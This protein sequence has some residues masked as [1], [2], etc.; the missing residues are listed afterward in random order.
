[1]NKYL[2]F[3]LVLLTLL[4]SACGDDDS[5]NSTTV[6]TISSLSFIGEQVIPDGAMLQ[7][8]IIGGLSS[9]D[10]SNGTYYIISDAPNAPIRFYTANLTFDATSFTNV[11]INTQ[12]ELLDADGN[13]FMS[14]EADPEAIRIDPQSGNVIWAS[15]G[16]VDDRDVDPFVR[17]ASLAGAYV[18]DIQIPSI[19]QADSIAGQGPRNNGTFEGLC[20]SQDGQ[21]YWVSM[22]LPLEQDGVS[23]VF[24]TDTDSPVRI[25]FIDRSTGSFGRQ[26]AYELGSVVRDG[27]FTVNGVVEILE[28]ATDKFLVLER[29]FATGYDDGGNDVR[30]YDVDAS[31]ATDI[32]SI[33]S[34]SDATYTS[35]TKTLLFDFESVRAQLSTVP[36]GTANVVDNIEGITFGPD[37]PNGNKSLV[38]VADNNFSAFGAQLNQFVVLEVIP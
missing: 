24:G 13:A 33:G 15:E 4:F 7:G 37:L 23:P 22:E 19:F 30:I 11:Q 10:Y 31:S 3:T 16:Y 5:G 28:Y 35:A 34:L 18:K 38:L 27:G 17:E 12:I 20:L 2:L 9:I 6:T 32:S 25:A 14:N 29:S 36:G 21:G 26:F 1:M 8:E